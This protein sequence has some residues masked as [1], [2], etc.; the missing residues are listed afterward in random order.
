VDAIEADARPPVTCRQFIDEYLPDYVDGAL[1]AELAA[2]LERHLEACQPCVAFLNTY[3]RIPG[4]AR[5]AAPELPPE[6]RA[7]L[8]RV[9]GERFRAQD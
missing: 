8:S 4:L 5:S 6:V 7:V 1:P 3:R 2:E 9:L